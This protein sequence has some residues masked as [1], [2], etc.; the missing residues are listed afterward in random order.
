MLRQAR[1]NK[2]IEGHSLLCGLHRKP[3]MEFGRDAH[4]ELPR[5]RPA[6]N[7]GG[8]G[9]SKA[10]ISA[11]A[12]TASDR[13]PSNAFS[14]VS[15]SHESEGISATVPT[16]SPSSCD[17]TTRYAYRSASFTSLHLRYHVYRF[18]DLPY[19][20]RLRFAAIVL[21]IDARIAAP[22]RTVHAMRRPFLARLAEIRLAN[23][24]EIRESDVAGILPHRPDDALQSTHE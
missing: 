22:R 7:R 8:R 12:S 16:Y 5:V 17:H 3:T 10:S 20:I 24:R 13:M 15:A 9:F 23:V 2:A 21:D 14:G 18:K 1:R 6:R 4:L 19:L 11:T